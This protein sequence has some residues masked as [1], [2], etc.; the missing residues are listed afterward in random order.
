MTARSIAAVALFTVVAE[1]V[2]RGS[3]MHSLA[4]TLAETRARALP[5]L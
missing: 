3:Y 1:L 4:L 5:P 2:K